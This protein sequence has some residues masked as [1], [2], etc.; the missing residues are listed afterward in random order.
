MRRRLELSKYTTTSAP[1]PHAQ[2]NQEQ[3]TPDASPSYPVGFFIHI[4]E[5]K[6]TS[7]ELFCQQNH[8]HFAPVTNPMLHYNRMHT[9]YIL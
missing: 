1:L 6:V 4:D 2:Q 3:V 9:S 5:Y 7:W 8:I